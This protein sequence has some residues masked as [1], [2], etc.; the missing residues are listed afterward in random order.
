L[1]IAAANAASRSTCV[2]H[3]SSWAR[4]ALSD[5]T[6][7][8]ARILVQLPDEEVA[9]RREGVL[10]ILRGFHIAGVMRP[11]SGVRRIRFLPSLVRWDA[12]HLATALL[13]CAE[14]EDLIFATHDRQL[15]TAARSVGF[16]VI[17]AP[18][19]STTR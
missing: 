6:V 9:L 14:H 5:R 7:D 1:Q 13:V 17:G 10:A 2:G 15:A 11:C 12:I 18:A 3:P 4:A 16:Q 19:S 8:R